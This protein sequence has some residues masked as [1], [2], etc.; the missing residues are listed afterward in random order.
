MAQARAEAAKLEVEKTV[1]RAPL[2][3]VITQRLAKLGTS[4]VRN[5]KLFEVAQLTP[6]EVRF[7]LAQSEAWQPQVGSQIQLALAGESRLVATARIQRLAPVADA[8]S[9]ARS[10][11]ARLPSGTNLIPGTAVSVLRPRSASNAGSWIPRAAFAANE[12]LQRGTSAVLFVVENDKCAARTV[13]LGAV[14]NDQ[15]EIRSGLASGDR[16]ILTPAPDLKPGASV[17]GTVP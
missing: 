7:Q 11:F 14:A 5:D 1:I 6:L 12:D 15:V 8:A 13:W 16:V 9:N 17:D 2:T 3:G 4:V 10:Y